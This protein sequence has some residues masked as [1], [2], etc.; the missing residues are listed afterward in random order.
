MELTRSI[1]QPFLTLDYMIQG[2]ENKLFDRKSARV[3][4]SDLAETISTFAN[5]YGGTIVIGIDEK[6]REI[7]GINF[8]GDEKLNEL[9]AAPKNHCVPMPSFRD[10][11][12]DVVNK[13][14]TN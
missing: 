12:L 11:L 6:T 13:A 4:P 8:I 10:E 1:F 3:K 14:A 7:E 2:S 5:A 9:I